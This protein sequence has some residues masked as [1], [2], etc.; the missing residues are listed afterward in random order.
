M[1]Q[2]VQ[3]HLGAVGVEIPLLPSWKYPEHQSTQQSSSLPYKSLPKC[4]SG[5]KE[6]RLTVLQTTLKGAFSQ[7]RPCSVT[8]AEQG[9][10]F[11]QQ[12]T[13]TAHSWE[14]TAQASLIWAVQTA[15]L[16]RSEP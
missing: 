15:E 12:S 7:C 13:R 5:H 10:T 6:K 16:E 8:L 4:G 2:D 1:V 14:S 9:L 3:C 11:G